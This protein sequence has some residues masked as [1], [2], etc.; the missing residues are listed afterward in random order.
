MATVDSDLL[1][2]HLVDIRVSLP[3]EG[4]WLQ[5]ERHVATVP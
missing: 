5:K 1:S 4:S 3:E 2:R